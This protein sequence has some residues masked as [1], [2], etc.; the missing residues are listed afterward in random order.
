M[1]DDV[2]CAPEKFGLTIVGSLSADLCYEFSM[3]VVWQR[4][5]DGALFWDTDSGCSCPSPFE[6][7]KSVDELRRIDDTSAFVREAR[8]W[9][10]G[11]DVA[12]D[13]V[14]RLI[15]KVR[16]LMKKWEAAA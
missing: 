7:C 8:S 12:R 13:D 2:Y 15:R 1:Y 11:E 9:A 14:E 16:R 4:A 5:A 3:L 6:G 10:T